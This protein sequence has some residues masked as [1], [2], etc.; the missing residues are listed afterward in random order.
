MQPVV[1]HLALSSLTPKNKPATPR[2]PLVPA[3][4]RATQ[5]LDALDST[6]R[7][8]TFGEL[9][10][11]V[12]LPKSSLH[13][14]CTSLASVG[15]LERGS[16]DRWQIGL[17]IVELARSRLRGMDLVNAF[18]YV[19]RNSPPPMETVVLSVLRG[20]DVTYVSVLQGDHPVAVRYEIGMRLPAA[21]TASGKAILAGLTDRR[22][23]QLIGEFAQNDRIAAP[24]KPI[25]A[26]INELNEIRAR[27]FSIDD[28]ETAL[29]MICA[30]AAIWAS[31][32]VGPAGAVALSTV[33]AGHDLADM[34]E[35]VQNMAGAISTHLG[36]AK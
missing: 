32:A 29:G 13:N 9:A 11:R 17:R 16:D 21:F 5:V 28:E 10:A 1:T 7:P 8:L 31:D 30:G 25:N 33:K 2:R 12:D 27:G 18:L 26:L 35:R 24:P 15:I 3:I 34:A 4:A 19:S 20:C 36:A 22:V 23:R 6:G 14:I